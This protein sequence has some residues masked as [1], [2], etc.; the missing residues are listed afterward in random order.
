MWGRKAAVGIRL[1]ATA[2]EKI[3]SRGLSDEKGPETWRA[4]KAVLTGEKSKCE[5]PR[6]EGEVSGGRA[7]S[8]VRR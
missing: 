4:G 3:L 6:W 5:A 8:P 7:K 2:V 1:P